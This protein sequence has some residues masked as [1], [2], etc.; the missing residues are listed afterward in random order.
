MISSVNRGG[1][2]IFGVWRFQEWIDLE[3]FQGWNCYNGVARLF[4][5]EPVT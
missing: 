2:V 1:F 5:I 4:A 3:G